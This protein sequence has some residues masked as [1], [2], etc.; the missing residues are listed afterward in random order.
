[1]QNGL[2]G[3]ILPLFEWGEFIIWHFSPG[4]R[5]AM[6]G[7]YETVYSEHVYR[8][9]SDFLHARPAWRVFL[10]KYPHEMI[11]LPAGIKVTELMKGEKGWRIAYGD[12]DSVLFVRNREELQ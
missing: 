7:R 2:Q 6:D 3:N 9:Y 12:K 4:C 8:E 5:V 10:E 11:L 1:M